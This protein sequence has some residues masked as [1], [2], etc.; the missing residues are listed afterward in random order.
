MR[1]VIP[2]LLFLLLFISGCE[3]YTG[4]IP[5]AICIKANNLTVTNNNSQMHIEEG[6]VEVQLHGCNI[7]NSG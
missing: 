2:I 7:N 5:E 3:A 1:Y 4:E 6:Q